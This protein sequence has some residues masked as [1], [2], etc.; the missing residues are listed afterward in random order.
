MGTWRERR[1]E[2]KEKKGLKDTI[3]IAMLLT[4]HQLNMGAGS[5][6]SAQAAIGG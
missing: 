4:S 3:E 2:M 6:F 5:W 1:R